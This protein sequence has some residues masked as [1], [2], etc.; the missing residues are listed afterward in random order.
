[1]CRLHRGEFYLVVFVMLLVVYLVTASPSTL[2][3]SILPT[4]AI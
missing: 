4:E 2:Q 3:A 1:M